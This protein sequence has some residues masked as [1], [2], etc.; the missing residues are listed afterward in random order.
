MSSDSGAASSDSTL[1]L[2]AKKIRS[3]FLLFSLAIAI[4]IVTVIQTAGVDAALPI[5]AILVVFFV[6]ALVYSFVE[7]DKGPASRVL[8]SVPDSQ[9]SEL[10]LEVWVK[11][12]G[13]NHAERSFRLGDEVRVCVRAT[14]DCYL[15]LLNVSSDGEMTILFPNRHNQNNRIQGGITH[16]I[17]SDGYGFNI[18]LEEPLGMDRL[19]AIAT[20]DPKPLLETQFDA[21]GDFFQSVPSTATARAMR[22][23]AANVE[24]QQDGSWAAASTEFEVKAR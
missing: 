14:K 10:S 8:E 20:L 15:T 16:E 24:K 1:Q 12:A 21:N 17:P 6:G 11:R 4:V 3:Q 5:G 23:V 9:G 2:I 22:V 19:K 18:V 13:V 7:K